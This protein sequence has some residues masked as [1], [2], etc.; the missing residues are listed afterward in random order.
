MAGISNQ[1]KAKHRSKR[2]S[3]SLFGLLHNNISLNSLI[4][5]FLI[6]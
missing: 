1:P 5:R 2:F 6:C 4:M 3:L